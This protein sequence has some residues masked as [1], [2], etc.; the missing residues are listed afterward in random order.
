MC[1]YDKY[2]WLV[3][4]LPLIHSYNFVGRSKAESEIITISTKKHHDSIAED[5]TAAKEK[6]KKLSEDSSGAKKGH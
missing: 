2:N 3:N 4:G 1:C 6:R 5:T